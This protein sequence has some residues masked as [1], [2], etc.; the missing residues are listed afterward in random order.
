MRIG[1]AHGHEDR[2]EGIAAD[3]F[4][5]RVGAVVAGEA[6]VAHDLLL[7]HFDEGFHGAALGE[8]LI[9]IEESADVVQ[10]PEV[11]VIS[12]EELKR[13]L[14]H[15]H[16]VVARARSMMGTATASLLGFSSDAWPPSEKMPTL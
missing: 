13:L 8:Y 2:V 14:D 16:G 6:E 1:G 3:P 10:L 11:D 5:Q 12:L 7:F 9:H 15:A 4:H